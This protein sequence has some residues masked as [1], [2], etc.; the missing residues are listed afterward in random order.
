MTKDEMGRMKELVIR[1]SLLSA[2]MLAIFEGN[3]RDEALRIEELK[4]SPRGIY[5]I[6]PG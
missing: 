4:K 6:C 5:F 2:E 3:A 1:L